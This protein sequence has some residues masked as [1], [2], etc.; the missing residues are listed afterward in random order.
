MLTTVV[1]VTAVVTVTMGA[2]VTAELMT[3]VVLALSVKRP[4]APEGVSVDSRDALARY[5]TGLS[6][7]RSLL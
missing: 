1:T 2:T 5:V 7:D 6:R 4:L 3:I